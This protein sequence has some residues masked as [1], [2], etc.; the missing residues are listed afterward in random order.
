MASEN[1]KAQEKYDKANTQFVGLKLN[2]KT[3]S[4]ILEAIE[5]KSKQTEIKRLIRIGLEKE[6]K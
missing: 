1:F 6:T 5:G 4:D 2:K 3:D